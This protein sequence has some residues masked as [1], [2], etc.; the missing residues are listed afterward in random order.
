MH[1]LPFLAAVALAA[2]VAAAEP[3]P[4][5]GG[6]GMPQ[7][8]VA[9]FPGQIFWLVVTFALLYWLLTKRALPR[10]AEILEARHARIAADLDRAARLRSEAEAALQRYEATLAEAQAT[11][12]A[13]VKATQERLAADIAASTAS[14]D[15]DLAA[16]L[17]EAERRI[18]AARAAAL[19]QIADVAAEAAQAAVQRLAGIAVGEGDARGAVERVLR[20]AA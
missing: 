3:E 11:A 10:V 7:L 2:P 14:L 15:R 5:T 18:A 1:L 17:A 4:G 8:D 9:T 6:G 20:E 12:A 16:R 13:E 19:D